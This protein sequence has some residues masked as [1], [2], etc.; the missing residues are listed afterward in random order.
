MQKHVKHGEN[1]EFSSTEYTQLA[2]KNNNTHDCWVPLVSLSRAS[3]RWNN[4]FYSMGN[5]FSSAMANSQ[6]EEE[7][8]MEPHTT[9]SKRLFALVR[10]D[11]FHA[12]TVDPLDPRRIW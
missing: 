10:P 11:S 4:A 5:M 1:H 9:H 12:N 8:G 6:R 7:L 3:C 2:S